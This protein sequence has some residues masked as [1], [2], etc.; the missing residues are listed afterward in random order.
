MKYIIGN[1]LGYFCKFCGTTLYWNL[2]SSP[3]LTGIAGG[4]F[5]EN[6]LGVPLYSNSSKSKFSWVK[7]P[8][9]L[10]KYS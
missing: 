6:P 10:K 9:R 3:D 1:F 4:C 7:L 5:V 2:S 8:W